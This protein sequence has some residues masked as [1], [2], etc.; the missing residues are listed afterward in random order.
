MGNWAL[1]LRV[2]PWEICRISLVFDGPKWVTS[3]HLGLRGSWSFLKG[4]RWFPQA[5]AGISSRLGGEGEWHW[6]RQRGC[7]ESKGQLAMSEAKNNLGSS[8]LIREDLCT[9]GC[10]WWG[11]WKSPCGYPGCGYLESNLRL[12]HREFSEVETSSKGKG[13]VDPLPKALTTY[14][15]TLSPPLCH[16]AHSSFLSMVI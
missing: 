10:H 7:R 2:T 16:P 11:A 12:F 15:P 8:S 5:S 1:A 6:A 14:I 4:K 13:P 3:L 9:G